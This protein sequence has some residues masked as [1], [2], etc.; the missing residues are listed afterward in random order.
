MEVLS[1]RVIYGSPHF[2]SLRRFYEDVLGLHVYR[3]YG[4]RE[5][6]LGV[7]FFL[8]GGFLEIKRAS[9]ASPP[10]T[11]WLQVRDAG[12]EERRLRDAGVEV[13]KGVARMPWGLVESCVQDP[14]GNDLHLV[15]V[16]DDHPLRHRP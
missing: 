1:S 2:D 8:G 3:E 6:I 15:E 11:L 12:A 16:P 14:A 5:E 13:T 4:P 7:V 9:T 10:V